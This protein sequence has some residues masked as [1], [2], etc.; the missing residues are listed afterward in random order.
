M[1]EI[2]TTTEYTEEGGEIYENNRYK[3]FRKNCK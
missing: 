1:K 3:S 2:K